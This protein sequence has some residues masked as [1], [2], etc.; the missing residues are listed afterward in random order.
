M[1]ARD[2]VGFKH[3]VQS[4]HRSVDDIT[5]SYGPWFWNKMI[6]SHRDILF[7]PPVVSQKFNLILLHDE[8]IELLK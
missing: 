7:F 2:H 5:K 6:Q 1:H 4:F 8:K 3:F